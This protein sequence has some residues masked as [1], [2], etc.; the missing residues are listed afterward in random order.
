MERDPDIGD[1]TGNWKSLIQIIGDYIFSLFGKNKKLSDQDENPYN[2]PW[3][4]WDTLNPWRE[5]KRSKA[6]PSWPREEIPVEDQDSYIPKDMEF[7]ESGWEPS[8]FAVVY[9]FYRW[10]YST[11]KL[12]YFT[13]S[14]NLWSKK[15]K[16]QP[17]RHALEDWNRRYTYA[18]CI[19]PWVNAM[20]L[21]TWALPDTESLV[22]KGKT[23]PS[24]SIDQNGC[25]Y[26]SSTE[27]MWVSFEFWLKQ[28]ENTKDPIPEDS[29]TMI[30]SS[31][32]EETKSLLEKLR[33]EWVSM[34]SVREIEN[35]IKTKKKVFH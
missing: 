34:K 26:L 1:S 3:M 19:V 10:K 8:R 20:P 7:W 28:L 14:T 5:N 33:A 32:S 11:W 9:P 2:I 16:L 29:E 30:F 15:R 25:V 22:V 17:L 13:P 31:L 35:Y 18:W 23:F 21:P 24:F 27:K 6:I 4:P 12:S